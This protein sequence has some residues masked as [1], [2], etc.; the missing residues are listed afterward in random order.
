MSEHRLPVTPAGLPRAPDVH[1]EPGA[2]DP[3]PG[4][5]TG[6]RRE[7]SAGLLT[8]L[9]VNVLLIGGGTGWLVSWARQDEDWGDLQAL[10]AVLA[11]GLVFCLSL[12]LG[13]LVVA[14]RTRRRRRRG[15][16]PAGTGAAV[17]AGTI[18]AATGLVAALLAAPAVLWVLGSV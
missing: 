8:V 7:M 3:A 16:A 18:A 13:M 2:P 11:G 14:L 15:P 10:V 17:A 4:R 6:W 1:L 5:P 12:P 9:A